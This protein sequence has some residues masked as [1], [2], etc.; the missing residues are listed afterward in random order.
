MQ[1]LK[2]VERVCRPNEE[3][4]DTNHIPEPVIIRIIKAIQRYW[5]PDYTILS[6]P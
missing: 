4:V 1:Y 5:L 6:F 3:R 2:P